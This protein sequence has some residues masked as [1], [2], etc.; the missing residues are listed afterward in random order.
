MSSDFPW[1]AK[2][3]T[4]ST[5]GVRNKEYTQ[6]PR[7]TTAREMELRTLALQSNI[8][9]FW[10]KNKSAFRQFWEG[11]TKNQRALLVLTVQP[12]APMSRTIGKSLSGQNAMGVHYL[13][14][15]LNVAELT[16]EPTHL[17][18]LLEAFSN[19]DHETRWNQQNTDLVHAMKLREEGKLKKE[20]NPSGF[21]LRDEDT[22]LTQNEFNIVKNNPEAL[23]KVQGWIETGMAFKSDDWMN[24]WLIQN[25][26]LTVLGLLLEEYKIEI[27]KDESNSILLPVV[28]EDFSSLN[29][30]P[31]KDMGQMS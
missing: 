10:I 29:F 13:V 11:I 12:D 31:T 3:V 23:Q 30:D 22:L 20:Q 26:R 16:T 1:S 15:D 5:N 19:F 28:I 17:L 18:N 21:V 27:M 6:R 7:E 25:T 2:D 14:P 9:K 4:A 24:G 8:A